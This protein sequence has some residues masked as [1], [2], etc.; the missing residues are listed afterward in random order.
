MQEHP[1]RAEKATTETKSEEAK[2]S[3]L[4]RVARAAGAALASLASRA[5]GEVANIALQQARA[6]T[7]LSP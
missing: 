2:T 6:T 4:L 1:R 7:H 3:V 5:S